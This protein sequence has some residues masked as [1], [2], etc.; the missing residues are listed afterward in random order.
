MA[1]SPWQSG[2]LFLVGLTAVLGILFLLLRPAATPLPPSAARAA[3]HNKEFAAVIDVRTPA[4]FAGGHYPAARSAP[5]STL[6]ATLPADYPDRDTAILFYCTTGQRAGRA[7]AIATDL[8]YTNI[9]FLIG[10]DY[11][12]LEQPIR[13]LRQ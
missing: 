9:A 6:V 1:T 8:G 3:L 11:T 12:T 7:A 10:G 5:L 13:I 4:E 2:M